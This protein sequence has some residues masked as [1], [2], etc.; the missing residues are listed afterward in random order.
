[1]FNSMEHNQRSRKETFSASF[2]PPVASSEA[3]SKSV[4]KI[5]KIN[6]KNKELKHLVGLLK[7]LR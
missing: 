3:R 1:M 2:N 6:E 7:I 4:N 5:Q